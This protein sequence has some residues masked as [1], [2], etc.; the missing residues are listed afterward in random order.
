MDYHFLKVCTVTPK[1]HL[2]DCN[3]NI[4]EIIK[5]MKEAADHG[6]SLAVYPELCVTGYSCGD[7]FQQS[8][9]IKQVECH[10][11]TLLEETKDLE[12]VAVLGV[13]IT[14][15]NSL[16]NTALVVYKGK[17]LGIVP[18]TYLPNYGEFY[19]KRWFAAAHNLLQSHT[20]YAG[21]D[22]PV[23]PH[24]LFKA[25]NIP[26]FTLGIDVCEDLW[27][28]LPPS[29]FHSLF[30]ATVLV[31]LSAS[32]EIIGKADYRKNMIAQHSSKTMSA[33]L[34]TSSSVRESTTDLVFSGH[35]LIYENGYLI[36]ESTLFSDDTTI[37]Y[38]IIDLERLHKERVRQNNICPTQLIEHLKYKI[39]LFDLVPSSFEF[40]RYIDPK[41][42][43]PQDEARRKERCKDIFDIQAH[44]LARRATHAK[45]DYLIFGMSGGLDS[46]LAL[47]VC[48]K[49][50][51][52]ANMD[53]KQILGVTMPGFGTSDRT[54]QNA[55]NLMNL[56]GITV[57]EVSIV[58][59]TKKHLE[60]IEHPLDLHDVTYENAQ[61]RER[62]QILMDL[63]NKYNGLVIGTADLSEM[64]LGWA[65]Y[66]GDHMSMYGVNSGLPKTLVRYLLDYV[67][68]YESEPLVQEILFDVLDTPVSPELLP[69]D[70][71]GQ[72]AQKTE[73]L[74]GPYELH[75]FYIYYVLRFG[76]SPSKIF[77][78]AQHAFKGQFDDATIFKWLY[79]FYTRF[80]KHQF[81]RSSMPDGPKIGSV[82]LSPR[83]DLRMPSD[84]YGD[85]WLNEMN[86]LKDKLNL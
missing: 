15:E 32:N 80:F 74:V 73:D 77:F 53:R 62:T 7:L 11:V 61:A 46:T 20:T 58:E 86:Q 10:I 40:N 27:A 68:H 35:Q 63:A 22:C 25:T 17:I 5:T 39:I 81:K 29:L 28:M 44:G 71:E 6:A 13:P 30:G 41:P 38:G 37:T 79:G 23:S 14:I 56:L 57:K 1:M 34:Y 83:G 66:S 51:E 52:Y 69:T 2:A 36:N 67:A 24:L 47:F 18:K 65:T 85:V 78:L 60:D 33:Y 75:D 3:Y 4:K 9:L 76:Y 64:A 45:S 19:E 54:Y 31:N 43:V 26:Y 59:A 55:V 21:Q 49:A 82:C 8:N 42:F 50:A 12:L 16:Y 84:A 48:I 72:I 70:S